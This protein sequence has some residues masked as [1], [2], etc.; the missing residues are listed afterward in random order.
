M[1]RIKKFVNK[2]IEARQREVNRKIALN[3][4]YKMSDRELQDLGIGRG[5]I[6]R[7]VYMS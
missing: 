3:Q 6:R 2:L 5:D 7:I 1:N 4:L